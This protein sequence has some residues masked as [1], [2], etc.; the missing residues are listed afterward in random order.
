MELTRAEKERIVDSRLKLQAV[1]RSLKGVDPNKVP[2]YEDIEECLE[3]AEKSLR[4]ALQSPK[5]TK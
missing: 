5:P 4:G 1:T 3:G 2:D